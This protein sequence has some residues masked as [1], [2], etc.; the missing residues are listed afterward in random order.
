VRRKR[1]Q[2]RI[3]WYRR[4]RGWLAA[5]VLLAAVLVV[6]LWPR[7]PAYARYVDGLRPTVVFV[8]SEPSP[9][10]PHT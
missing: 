8:W 6:L 10:M 9:E 1:K 7:G 5:G 2:A 4:Y 3:P